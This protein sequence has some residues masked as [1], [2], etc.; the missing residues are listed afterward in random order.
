MHSLYIVSGPID[1]KKIPLEEGKYFIGRGS[2]SG[3][4]LPSK[5][6]SRKHAQI[7]V[8]N[9]KV[10]LVDLGSSNG[11]LVN[12]KA[13]TSS[14]L[15]NKDQVLFGDV[16]VEFQSENLQKSPVEDQFEAG[17]SLYVAATKVVAGSQKSK[18]LWSS[19]FVLYL[20]PLM[21]LALIGSMSFKGLLQQR[22]ATESIKRAQGLV[23]YLAEK[24]KEDLKV[25]NDLLLDTDS[26][27]R[28]SGV[29][30]AFIINSKGR[31]LS[32]ISKINQSPKDP[33]VLEALSHNSDQAI[34]PSPTLPD[35]SQIFVHPIRDYDES[36]GRYSILG[37]A[38][39]VFSTQEAA[40][41]LTESKRLSILFVALAFLL[42]TLF[43]WLSTKTIN[44]PIVRLAEKVHQWRTGQ[45][46][47]SQAASFEDWN[48]L[49][50][51]IE[52]T[53]EEADR[54]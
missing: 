4:Q 29:M 18:S 13:I 6:I 45:V 30:E 49:Y 48:N 51:A 24:N 15:Q 34:P 1:R 47:Q 2:D 20:I 32:P 41:E 10:T 38:K 37:V 28:E 23:R 16:L 12:G 7:I 50:E 46:Y 11:T 53:I 5:Q 25:K 26:V 44:T 17:K 9:Q 52:R 27:I 14:I 3:V 19:L 8:E 35:G 54:K 31:I 42:A 39:I 22:L 40:G 43:S 36:I 33:F 21:V